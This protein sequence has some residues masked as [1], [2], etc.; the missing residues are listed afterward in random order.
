M[1]SE[2]IKRFH[3]LYVGQ[4]DLENIGLSGTPANTRRYNNDKLSE[5]FF[6]GA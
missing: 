5:P 6:A 2:M 1:D 3:V 4:V